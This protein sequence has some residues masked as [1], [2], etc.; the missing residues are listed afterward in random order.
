MDSPLAGVR[1]GVTGRPGSGRRTVARALRAAGW[2]IGPD[3]DADVG[4]YV[5]VETLT[6]DDRAALASTVRPTVALLNKADLSG[7]R[8]DGP[9]ARAARR[10]REL[11]RETFNGETFTGETT[12]AVRP[13]S[14]LLALAGSDPAVLDQTVFDAVKS[15]AGGAGVPEGMRRR[16]AA[17]L[18]L[19]GTACAVSAVRSGACRDAVAELL[20]SVSGLAQVGLE[21]D[22]A[23]ATVRYR[24]FAGPSPADGDDVVLARMAAASAVVR[25]AGATDPCV[26][27]HLRR[28]IHWHRYA[29]G[30][31]S[32]L[33]RDAALDIARGAL[34]LWAQTG[35]ETTS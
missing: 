9:M 8:G 27:G 6:A 15:L 11:Q 14:A 3:T 5:F 22:R 33:H 30:P 12:F 18:D 35:G 24:R 29:R 20:R 25:A 34:R 13:F 10:C 1:V 7:F 23:A 28:A 16:L 19:F 4:V 26:S 2:E 32:S 31:V 17:D 21:I